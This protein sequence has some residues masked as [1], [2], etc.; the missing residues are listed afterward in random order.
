MKYII[1]FTNNTTQEHVE[2]YLQTNN[3]TVTEHLINLGHVYVGDTDSVPPPDQLIDFIMEN[4]LA[5]ISLMSVSPT[6]C[7]EID[8]ANDENWWKLSTINI[9]D[10]EAQR[11]NHCKNITPVDVYVMD[12]GINHEHPEFANVDIQNVYSYDGTFNDLTGHGTAVASL[13]A[14][15]TLSLANVNLKIVKVIGQNNL[16]LLDLLRALDAIIG[17]ASA[18]ENIAV[19]NMSWICSKFSFFDAQIEKLFAKNILVVCAA[20]NNNMDVTFFSPASIDAAICVGAYDQNFRPCDYANY[21]G[22]ISTSPS[23]S[24]HGNIDVWAPGDAIKVATLTGEYAV[25]GGTSLAAAIHTSAVAYALGSYFNLG[26][27]PIHKNFNFYT[28]VAGML[29]SYNYGL[30]DFSQTQGQYSNIINSRTTTVKSQINK[31]TDVL[32]YD[33]ANKFIVKNNGLTFVKCMI[34]N[35]VTDVTVTG[36][37]N[38]LSLTDGWIVGKT[39]V[40]FPQDEQITQLTY[41]ATVQYSVQNTRYTLPLTIVVRKS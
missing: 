21:T 34:T 41:E 9:S 11:I 33:T 26:T 31:A 12:S 29:A 35:S 5:Q 22:A 2:Q 39:I 10:F 4:E 27:V 17:T 7:A 18:S 15:N 38:G 14:G 8:T 32:M 36:L 28:V 3:I 25:A 23:L 30:V 24:N 37:P 6:S 20:G 40:E 13:I 16:Y 19:V 1:S